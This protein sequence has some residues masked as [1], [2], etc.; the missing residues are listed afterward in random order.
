MGLVEQTMSYK[1][2]NLKHAVAADKA[3]EE[4]F[5]DLSE[6]LLGLVKAFCWE[7]CV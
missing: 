1:D 5:D 2:L 3:C 7:G 4:N 6:G